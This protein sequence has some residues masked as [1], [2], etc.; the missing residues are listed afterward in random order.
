MLN[1][2]FA[3]VMSRP[4]RIGTDVIAETQK[5]I[6]QKKYGAASDYLFYAKVNKNVSP[7]KFDYKAHNMIFVRAGENVGHTGIIWIH[8]GVTYVFDPN[9]DKTTT[10]PRRWFKV[11]NAVYPL[12][13]RQFAFNDGDEVDT[14]ACFLISY[15]IRCFLLYNDNLNFIEKL[16]RLKFM[17]TL[18]LFSYLN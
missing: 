10:N 8:Q 5:L 7:P 6:L 13:D 17:S 12:L 18:N 11:P 9:H 3:A 14:G 4:K 2:F 1:I 15:C 16:N